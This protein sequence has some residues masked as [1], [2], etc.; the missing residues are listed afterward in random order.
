M[1][2][3]RTVGARL[4]KLVVVDRDFGIN[5]GQG[6]TQKPKTKTKT[7]NFTATAVVYK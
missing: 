5:R 6:Q 4:E 3:A 1:Q 7:I 2:D